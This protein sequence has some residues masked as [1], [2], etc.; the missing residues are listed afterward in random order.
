[1]DIIIRRILTK[2]IN[3]ERNRNDEALKGKKF[4]N[5]SIFDL[6]FAF[7]LFGLQQRFIKKK[8]RLSNVKILHDRWLE[9]KERKDLD[10]FLC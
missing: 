1:M 10:F 2:G 5:L 9:V 8:I 6:Y 7:N 3:D 4:E